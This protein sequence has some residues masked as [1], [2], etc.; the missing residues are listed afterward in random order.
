VVARHI[1]APNFERSSFLSKKALGKWAL[2]GVGM[3][4]DWKTE[5]EISELYPV[6]VSWLQKLRRPGA[7][8]P[9]FW[10]KNPNNPKSAVVYKLSEFE[11]WWAKGRVDPSAA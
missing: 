7:D 5:K 6:S 9:P 8:G 2:E 10:K 3:S 4:N 11:K 1:L